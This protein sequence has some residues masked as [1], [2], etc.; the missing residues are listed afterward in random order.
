MISPMTTQ[1]SWKRDIPHPAYAQEKDNVS[2]WRYT[3]L[4]KFLWTLTESKLFLCRA[5]LLGDSFEGSVPR[6]N[7]AE[8][9]ELLEITA[10]EQGLEF[11]KEELIRQMAPQIKR[12]R[13]AYI[14]SSFVNC[15]SKGPESEAMWRLYCGQSEGVAVVSSFG[16]LNA[17]LTDKYARL[18]TVQYLDYGADLLPG[19][20]WLMPIMH[21]RAAY[22][23]E[24]EVRLVRWVQKE[25]D[26]ILKEGENFDAPKGIEMDWNPESAYSTDTCHAFHVKPATQTAAKLPPVPRDVCH[27]AE[28]SDALFSEC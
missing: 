27:P 19:K 6:K 17:S 25:T 7:Q 14:R 16:A 4:G 2:V 8:M 12:N 28:R 21:K 1:E 26:E 11:S 13:M 9:Y 18:G 10:R 3:D 15:W 24:R 20:N 5:D 23:H 22:S